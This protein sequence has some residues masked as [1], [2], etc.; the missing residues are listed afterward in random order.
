MC[1]IGYIEILKFFSLYDFS[2]D[3]FLNWPLRQ[4]GIQKNVI[5]IMTGKEKIASIFELIYFS[6]ADKWSNLIYS[7]SYQSSKKL[8]MTGL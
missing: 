3:L 5:W 8:I 7:L 6:P 1:I 2:Q 4:F